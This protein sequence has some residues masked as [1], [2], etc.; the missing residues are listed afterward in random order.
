MV[1]PRAKLAGTPSS[2]TAG[3]AKLD[4]A[5]DPA[6][7]LLTDEVR[8]YLV[9]DNI[10]PDTVRVDPDPSRI[11]GFSEPVALIDPGLGR[12]VRVVAGRL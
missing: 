3:K 8:G 1:G 11:V 12:F 9:G 6:G 7:D 4:K 10:L 2:S 5:A